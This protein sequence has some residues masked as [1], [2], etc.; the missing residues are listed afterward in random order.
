MA[1]ISREQAEMVAV[2]IGAID[3]GQHMIMHAL[4]T[5]AMNG[6]DESFPGLRADIDKFTEWLQAHHAMV[7]EI[8]EFVIAVPPLNIEVL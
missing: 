6:G 7:A 3:Q 8:G 1:D 4:T 2:V 5:L